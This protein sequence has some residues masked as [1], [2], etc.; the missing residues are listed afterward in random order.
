MLSAYCPTVSWSSDSRGW[1]DG[2][3][4]IRLPGARKELRP[5]VTYVRY[6]AVGAASGVDRPGAL[7]ARADG[8]FPLVVFGHG[9]AVTPAIYTPLLMAWARAGYV[10]AAPV[11]P[12]ENAHAPGGPNEADIVNQPADVSF[13][14]SRMLSRNAAGSAQRTARTSRQPVNAA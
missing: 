4:T 2:S 3:R 5:V 8:P 7:P 1:I 14:I 9:F 13:V 10:V 11:F 6:P 12:L